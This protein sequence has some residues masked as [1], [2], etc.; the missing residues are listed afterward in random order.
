[1]HDGIW[2]TRPLMSWAEARGARRVRARREMAEHF[3][4]DGRTRRGDGGM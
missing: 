2:L 4:L 1:M 3:M